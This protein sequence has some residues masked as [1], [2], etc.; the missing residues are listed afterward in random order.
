MGVV[1][2]LA[3]NLMLLYQPLPVI[4][5]ARSTFQQMEKAP[6]PFHL[7]VHGIGFDAQSASIGARAGCNCPELDKA[8]RH[9][10]KVKIL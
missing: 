9:D 7:T 5:D 4:R 2:L 1:H 6:E 3:A 10:A 8:L